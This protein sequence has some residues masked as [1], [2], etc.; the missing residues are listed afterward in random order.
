MSG[1]FIRYLIKHPLFSFIF[2]IVILLGGLIT[3]PSSFAPAW[4]PD[5]RVAVDA[6]PEI[7]SHQQIVH[8]FWEGKSPEEVEDQITYPLLTHLMGLPGLQS[9]R[10]TSM[11]GRSSIYLS[12]EKSKDAYWCRSRILEKLNAIPANLLPTDTEPQLG[13]NAS[14][15]G[16]I[17]WYTIEGQDSL[18]EAVKAWPLEEL[19]HINDYFIRY[20][21]QSVEQVAEVSSIGGWKQTFHVQIDPHKMKSLGISL[22]HIL[23]AIQSNN[24]NTSGH[25]LE[26]NRME[27]FIRGV[28]AIENLN[29][30][31]NVPIKTSGTDAVYLKDLA[32][33][34]NG[35][36]NRR[37]LLDK[38]GEAA[39]GGVLTMEYDANPTKVIDRI[40]AKLTQLSL[41]LPSKK[42]QDGRTIQLKIVPFY[43][44]ANLVQANIN[45]LHQTLLFELL[46]VGIVVFF[47]M[48]NWQAALVIGSMLPLSVALTY[49]SMRLCN[50]PAN[51]LSLAGIAIAIGSIV[52]MGI[53]WLD[54]LL[55]TKTEKE[56]WFNCITQSA[57]EIFPAILTATATTIVS[58]LPIIWLQ[59][60]EGQLFS[61]L[62]ITKTIV[63]LS[64]FFILFS[65]IPVLA[66]FL[67]RRKGQILK[68]F[69]A[70]VVVAFG[71]VLLAY[72]LFRREADLGASTLRIALFVAILLGFKKLSSFFPNILSTIFQHHK[73]IRWIP[74]LIIGLGLFVW[75][76]M[77]RS[78]LPKIDEGAFLLMPSVPDHLGETEIEEILQLLDKAIAQIPEVKTVVGKAGHVDSALDPAPLSMLEILIQY[79]AE[80]GKDEQGNFRR[81]W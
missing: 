80:Y 56:H 81:L 57:S 46:I 76:N 34:T 7:G 36:E 41:G 53:I 26:V 16:Q 63:L 72:L 66:Y 9:T 79:C 8:T 50:I 71:I 75:W 59:G 12:F 68:P 5:Y 37:G 60:T 62:A 40:E 33:I 1:R 67:I 73:K 61:P 39:V 48:R 69:Q 38:A 28:G 58:F 19:R 77:E 51:S 13:P 44:R 4:L 3:V 10:S 25:T 6:I 47:M 70:N 45:T 78:Y 43:N 18:G 14:A 52:D 74:F 49:L 17:F 24:R 2:L 35:R 22:N 64:S 65:I 30:L 27:Y 20:G 21:L 42:L 11:F 32:S 23:K 15:L 55:Q 31:S 54:H 29:D